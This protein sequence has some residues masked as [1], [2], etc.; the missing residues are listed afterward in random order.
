MCF[1][2]EANTRR[3]FGL[4]IEVHNSQKWNDSK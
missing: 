2:L 1:F 4:A 3:E